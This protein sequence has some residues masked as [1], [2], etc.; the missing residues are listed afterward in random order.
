[1][2]VLPLLLSALAAQG[3][4]DSHRRV[5]E[6]V[7]RSVVAVRALAPLGE[8]SGSGV[9]LSAESMIGQT[10]VGGLGTALLLPSSAALADF[11]IGRLRAAAEKW[12]HLPMIVIAEADR[13][14][15]GCRLDQTIS[16][17]AP[18]SEDALDQ[19]TA[20]SPESV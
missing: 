2:N 18:I 10:A 20:P 12:P 11:L 1:M 7:S 4:D 13:L 14:A 15:D 3:V 17:S 6:K 19:L 9:V 8:R 16:R 5:Y